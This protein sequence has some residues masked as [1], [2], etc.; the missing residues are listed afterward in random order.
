MKWTETHIEG[1]KLK[2][3]NQE[4][5]L[6]KWK[7]H[8]ENLLRHPPGNHWQ[9]FLKNYQWPTRCQTRASSRKKNQTHYWK[10]KEAVQSIHVRMLTSLSVIQ[11][12]LP[13]CVNMSINFRSFLF[14][15]EISL[16]CLKRMDTV[17]WVH[18]EVNGSICLLPY[19]P[20]P[21]ARAGYDTRSIFKWSL[22]GLNSEFFLL[23]D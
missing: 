15:V 14:D 6:L 3:S 17:F 16:S 10:K 13:R 12:L 20:N 8:F 22:T 21:S 2:A 18:K 7:E 19:S 1:K 5:T 11:M 23:L 9:N 4:E